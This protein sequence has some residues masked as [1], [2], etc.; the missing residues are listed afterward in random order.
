MQVLEFIFASFWHFA[1]CFLILGL[2]VNGLVNIIE[3]LRG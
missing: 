2:L 3:A 1:G